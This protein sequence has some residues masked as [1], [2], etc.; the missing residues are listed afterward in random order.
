MRCAHA[1][2]FIRYE[3]PRHILKT[4][5]QGLEK[6]VFNQCSTIKKQIPGS[7]FG[8]RAKSKAKLLIMMYATFPGALG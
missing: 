1:L 6:K 8:P 3:I 2:V 7:G 4:G 5:E